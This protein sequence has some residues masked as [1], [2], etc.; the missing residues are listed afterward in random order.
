M[1]TR[2]GQLGYSSSAKLT[3]AMRALGAVFHGLKLQLTDLTISNSTT[4]TGAREILCSQCLLLLRPG[5]QPSG[6]LNP[7]LCLALCSASAR[8]TGWLGPCCVRE[9]G[10]R[11]DVRICDRR[12]AVLPV[13]ACK[14]ASQVIWIACLPVKQVEDHR[15]RPQNV[16]ALSEPAPRFHAEPLRV[17]KASHRATVDDQAGW[18]G[19]RAL[20]SARV[21]PLQGFKQIDS[22]QITHAR[23]LL[24]LPSAS[25]EQRASKAVVRAIRPAPEKVAARQ[26]PLPEAAAAWSRLGESPCCRASPPAIA[27]DLPRSVRR[28]GCV[29]TGHQR[30]R[31]HA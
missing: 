27:A 28:Q 25:P 18:R 14:P 13:T 7:E 6:S 12:S 4:L 3:K 1:T 8:V 23:I 20:P 17:H 26:S 9:S 29:H 10:S 5:M 15:N 24:Q 21:L 19:V 30:R 31:A 2:H 16:G 11:H 22:A